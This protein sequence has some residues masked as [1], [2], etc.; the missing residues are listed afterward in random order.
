MKVNANE[1]PWRTEGIERNFWGLGCTWGDVKVGV[2]SGSTVVATLGDGLPEL[3]GF[4]VQGLTYLLSV[5]DMLCWKILRVQRKCKHC[6]IGLEKFWTKLCLKIKQYFP[7]GT[8]Y[9][10]SSVKV[11]DTIFAHQQFIDWVLFSSLSPGI[12][13]LFLEKC[14]KYL[15][16]FWRARIWCRGQITAR[17]GVVNQQ[18]RS[19]YAWTVKAIFYQSSS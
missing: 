19:W 11:K 7:H 8:R 3:D 12:K 4:L 13:W 1:A 5:Q 15:M 16:L 17:P 14:G 10:S 9:C 2:Y 6:A 18:D